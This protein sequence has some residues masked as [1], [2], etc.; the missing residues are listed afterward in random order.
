[1]SQAENVT[2]I[3]DYKAS[4]EA[5]QE[6]IAKEVMSSTGSD[7]GKVSIF[8]SL[9]AVLLLVV[10]FFGLNQNISRLSEEVEALAGLRQDVSAMGSR[11][12]GVTNKVRSVDQ[13]VAGLGTAMTTMEGRVVELEKL[14]AKT[15]N[16]MIVNDLNAIGGKLG[17]I[18]G[19]LDSAQA[20]KLA[21]AQ[22]LLKDL[23]GELAK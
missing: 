23:E 5:A 15:R 14:P 16:M 6:A 4:D 12:D 21:Q 8:I 7:M 10:F 2:P 22:K 9:L 20:A 17:F 18:G 1:M 19:K 13:A 3:Q 11:L